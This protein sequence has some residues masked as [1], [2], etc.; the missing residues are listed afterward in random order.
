MYGE[1]RAT[2]DIDVIL[3]LSLADLNRLQALFP[4]NEFYLPPVEALVTEVHRDHRGM[5]N[6]LH[7]GSGYKAD[8][9]LAARDPLHAW[10]LRHRHRKPYNEALPD[11]DLIWVAPPEYIIL[12]KLEYFR[13]GDDNKHLRDIRFMLEVTPEMDRA[14][15]DSQIER[16]GLQAQWRIVL[17]PGPPRL[18]A[19]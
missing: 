7:H 8:L 13:E 11:Q 15:M 9:F 6:L 3:A 14:F 2:R 19:R 12:R 16:L 1:P 5:F 4:E 17:E 10:A 18:P